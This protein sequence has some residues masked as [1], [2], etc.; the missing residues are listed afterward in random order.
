MNNADLVIALL[1]LGGFVVGFLQGSPRALIA[2]A[3]WALTFVLAA[4]LRAPVGDFLSRTA[5]PYAAGYAR[6]LGFGIVF[7]VTLAAVFVGIAVAYR[8]TR[9]LTRFTLADELVGGLLGLLVMLL[10]LSSVIVVLDSYYA[11]GAAGGGDIGWITDLDRSL[12]GSGIA[13]AVRTSLIPV[14]G[15]VLDPLLPSTVRAVMR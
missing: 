6:M 12:A 8:D 1:L 4:Q 7:L 2:L 14:L 9:H 15:A 11:A 13:N 10:V 5:T 3:G